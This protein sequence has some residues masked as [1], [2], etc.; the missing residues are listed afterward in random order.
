MTGAGLAPA[1]PHDRAHSFFSRAT[2]EDLPAPGAL[3]GTRGVL[4][5]GQQ[6]REDVRDPRAMVSEVVPCLPCPVGEH[7]RGHRFLV[8]GQHVVVRQHLFHPQE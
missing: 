8:T 7:G 4:Q 6:S 5:I 3:V 2:D 1:W